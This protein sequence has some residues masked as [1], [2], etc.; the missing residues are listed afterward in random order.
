MHVFVHMGVCIN[1]SMYLSAECITKF[2]IVFVYVCTCESVCVC[3]HSVPAEFLC[4]PPGPWITP[5]V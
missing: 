3:T 2:L 4:E 1:V 5:A